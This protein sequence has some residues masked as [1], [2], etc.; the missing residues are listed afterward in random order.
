MLSLLI[1]SLTI[2]LAC[3][4]PSKPTTSIVT[5]PAK[6]QRA[7]ITADMTTAQILL[8]YEKL[9]SEWEAWGNSVDKIINGAK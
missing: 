9:V 4:T 1:L 7:E 3:Q 8:Y 5:L 2:T 6:P